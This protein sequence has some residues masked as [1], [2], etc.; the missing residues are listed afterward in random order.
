MNIL[1][2]GTSSGLGYGLTLNYLKKGHNVHGISRKHNDELD[3][4][5]NF[6]FLQQDLSQFETSQQTVKNFLENIDNLDIVIL[7]AGILNEIKDTRD[8]TID[9]LKRVMD[10]NVW[11][12]KNLIDV[13]TDNVQ[14]IGQV[15]GISSGASQGAAR[16]WN[17]YSISKSSLNLLLNHYAQELP[18]IHFCALAPGLIDSGM[19]DYLYTVDRDKFPAVKKLQDAK[20]TGVMPDVHEAAEIVTKAIPKVKQYES[21]SYADVREM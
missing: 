20:R 10:I 3:L 4:Y 11:A 21:G 16:G 2:T 15:I 13:L 12:N 7:N 19:Q 17:A 8:I 18:D 5:D 9:E 1:I 6:H 14:S